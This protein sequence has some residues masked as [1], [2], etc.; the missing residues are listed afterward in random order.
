MSRALLPALLLLLAGCATYDTAYL[1]DPV[2]DTAAVPGPDGDAGRV[3][4]RVLGIREAGADGHAAIDVRLRLE[5]YGAT[6]VA[7]PAASLRIETAAKVPAPLHAIK[8]MGP[9]VPAQGGACA[10]EATFA[11]PGRDPSQF[12]LAGLSLHVPVDVGGKLESVTLNFQRGATV[13]LWVD[14]WNWPGLDYTGRQ[15]GWR[16]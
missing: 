2:T 13:Y 14:P 11:L 16:E 10:F 4:A 8:A 1:F 5:R 15:T 7:L 12:D 6:T 9:E 3:Q